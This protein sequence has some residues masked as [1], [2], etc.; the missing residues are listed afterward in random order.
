MEESNQNLNIILLFF[1]LVIRS[2]RCIVYQ[3]ITAHLILESFY[4]FVAGKD[5]SLQQINPFIG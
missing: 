2:N 1:N 4:I 3:L 5:Q